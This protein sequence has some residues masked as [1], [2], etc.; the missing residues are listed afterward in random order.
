MLDGA[1]AESTKTKRLLAWEHWIRFVRSADYQINTVNPTQLEIC[2]WLTNLS[3]KNYS[4]NSI[5]T[6]LYSLASE[7]QIRG[8]SR[9]MTKNKSWF[10]HSTL[11]SI[12]KS[13][14]TSAISWRRPLTIDILDKI[15]NSITSK[16]H[17][18]LQVFTP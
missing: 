15:T 10:I 3:K 11:R 7:I 13:S 12:Q 16:S 1:H 6:Y 14:G 17:D 18:D 9:I 4:Y 8:G 2:L 5:R